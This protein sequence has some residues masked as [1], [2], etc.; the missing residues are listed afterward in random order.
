VQPR[1]IADEFYRAMNQLDAAGVTRHYAPNVVFHDPVFGELRGEDPSRMWRMLLARAKDMRVAHEI[2]Q[3]D[4]KRVVTRWI[5]TYTF[6]KTGRP[7][8][9]VITATMDVE[10]GKIVRHTDV[11]SF[12]RWA[13]QALGP[14]GMLL[15]W[16][17]LV[18]GKVRAE[19]A[20]SLAKAK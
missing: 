12:Y 3:A 14:V 16:T 6:Q 13:R 15:G 20:A 18:Q 8:E 7:V 2:L 4:D 9:N 1:Q 19:A 10:N 11:F 5:A 17:P